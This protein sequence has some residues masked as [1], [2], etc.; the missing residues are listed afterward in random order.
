MSRLTVHGKGGHGRVVASAAR[1]TGLEVKFTD[2]A[3][4]TEPD[5]LSDAII[6]IGNNRTRKE[7]GSGTLVAVIHPEAFVEVSARLGRGVFIGPRAVVHVGA[8]VGRGAIVNTAAIVEHDCVVGDWV[9]LAP[10]TVL[11]G[12]VTVGEGVLVGA[13][14][15]VQPGVTIAPWVIV[16]SGSNVTRDITQPGTYA[17][18][19]AKRLP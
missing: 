19:P 15:T 5:P 18:N 4:G 9:H 14:A 13:N 2:D 12:G 7:R 11:C 8:Q 16:G 10:G 1:L 6:A 17:G 3:D